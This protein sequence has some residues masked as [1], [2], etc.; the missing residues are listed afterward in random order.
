MKNQMC[1]NF[2]V[3]LLI[4]L[5]SKMAFS[6]PLGRDPSYELEVRINN[7]G[8]ENC[9]LINISTPFPLTNILIDSSVPSIL[10]SSGELYKFTIGGKKIDYSIS[11]QCGP[12]KK[13]TL[14]MQQYYKK[15]HWHSSNVMNMENA[16]DVFE[17]H[18]TKPACI[19]RYTNICDES[20]T[21]AWHIS[22]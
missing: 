9:S 11:Y 13:F 16:V 2:F 7:N 18:E 1:K 4:I 19:S 21:I 15:N 14:H 20:G 22:N 10:A 3:T 17:T 5:T 6:E 12:Y 8:T